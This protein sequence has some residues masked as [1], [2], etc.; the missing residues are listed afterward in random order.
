MSAEPSVAKILSTIS[1]FEPLDAGE[2]E[3]LAV[4]GQRVTVPAGEVI[5]SE[6]D[7][8][9]TLYVLLSGAAEVTAWGAD[10]EQIVVAT[11]S[12][13]DFFGEIALLDGCPRSATVTTTDASTLFTLERGEFLGVV[14][15]NPEALSRVLVEL[16]QRLRE[17]NERY[18]QAVALR[19]HAEDGT[20]AGRLH[21]H[22]D[23]AVG[24]GRAIGA[25]LGVA[26][27][28]LQ[29]AQR[30]LGAVQAGLSDPD[31]RR[32]LQEVLGTLGMVTENLD[33]ARRIA[34]RIVDSA[35]DES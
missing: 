23:A 35:D 2:V 30:R 3:R 7:E 29:I 8:G 34:V 12:D 14:G 25:P 10:G 13:G 28:A 11:V 27:S 21:A 5:F 31:D 22:L 4:A 9:E 19:R 16:G 15:T 24:L 32:A 20:D 1:F 18:L 33:Q 6:G 26:R 17:T